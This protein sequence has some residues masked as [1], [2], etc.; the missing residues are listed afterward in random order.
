MKNVWVIGGVFAAGLAFGWGLRPSDHSFTGKSETGLKREEKRVK[1]AHEAKW[2]ILGEQVSS[3]N[4]TERERFLKNLEPGDRFK[5]LKALATQAGPRGLDCRLEEMM[6]EIL[7][8]LAKDDFQQAWAQCL[9]L[10]PGGNRR[11]FMQRLLSR[12]AKS[13][14]DK[15]LALYLECSASD[16]YFS[17]EV[18][19]QLAKEKSKEGNQA[20][21]DFWKKLPASESARLGGDLFHNGTEF[22]PDFDFAAGAEEIQRLSGRP[23]TPNMLLRE[24]AKRDPERAYEH[25]KN[26]E[27]DKGNWQALF[28]GMANRGGLEFC[29]AWVA[30]KLED[31]NEPRQKIISGIAHDLVSPFGDDCSE[32]SL[33]AR[34]ISDDAK[35]DRF[36]TEVLTTYPP[37]DAAACLTGIGYSLLLDGLSSSEARLEVIRELGRLQTGV[38]DL[39]A[40]EKARL[41]SWGLTRQQVEEALSVKR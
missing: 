12:Y 22:P 36:L 24:W 21:F 16:P 19:V 3:Y 14:P 9:S 34:A 27:L 23:D 15:A 37:N 5:A 6:D 39:S 25:W 32:V 10:E 35:R 4:E 33:V 28:F 30:G 8:D 1:G 40:L 2:R 41:S 17:S 13:E 29:A 31:P 20:L 38:P 26:R 7:D 11:Y 18:L